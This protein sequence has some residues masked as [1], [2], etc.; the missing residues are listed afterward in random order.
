MKTKKEL[1]KEILQRRDTLHLDK[2]KINSHKIAEQVCSME[3]F[4]NADKVL[5]FASY[6]SEVNTEE[7]FHTAQTQ[8]KELY[9]PKVIGKEM[10]FFRV[11]EKEDLIEGYRG[12]WE[13]EEDEKRKFKPKTGDRIFILMP[14]AVFDEDGNRI[15]YGGGYYDKFLQRLKD[16]MED[17]LMEMNA[18]SIVAV[19]FDCQIVARGQIQSE[20]H[21]WRVQYIVTESRTITIKNKNQRDFIC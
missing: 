4:Q 17:C 21:D 11:Q 6:K 18:V 15:G 16:K 9:F 8:G 10:D 20:V 7:I 5:L 3:E 14:G 13:P 1:R 12:I 19:A 2:Q